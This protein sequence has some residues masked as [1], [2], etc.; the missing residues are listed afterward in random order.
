MP[1]VKLPTDQAIAER[2]R[3]RLADLKEQLA[4]GAAAPARQQHAVEL[5][6]I[7]T[8]CGHDLVAKPPAL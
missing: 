3:A 1:T 7:D 8:G 5:W 6:L 4:S 2:Y